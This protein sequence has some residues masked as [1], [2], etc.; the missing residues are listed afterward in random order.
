MPTIDVE[1]SSPN[2]RA[3]VAMFSEKRRLGARFFPIFSIIF[4][5]NSRYSMT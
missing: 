3:T 5:Q 4:D 2:L 1:G